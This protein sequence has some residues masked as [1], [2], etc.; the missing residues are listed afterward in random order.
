MKK[1]VIKTTLITLASL[2]GTLIIA[3]GAV[4]IFAPGFTAGI[5]DGV[6]NYSATVF[7]YE[8][9]YAKTGDIDDLAVL[10]NKI[11]LD[12]DSVRAEKY[13]SQLV[14]HKDFDNFCEEP[15][16]NGQISKS[17]FYCGNYVYVLAVRDKFDQAVIFAEN[18]VSEN[19][20]TK[21]NPY[22]ILIYGVDEITNV[23]LQTILNKLN[24]LTQTE[25][26]QQDIQYINQR[27]G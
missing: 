8:K 26:V 13:L 5:F 12:S 6:G 25:T 27:L 7:F 15:V 4:A 17:E 19:S 20:Y 9:Q 1:L 16:Q 18:Y 3:F 23:Q 24:L 14:E 2:I 10:V 21:N 22:T 11:D